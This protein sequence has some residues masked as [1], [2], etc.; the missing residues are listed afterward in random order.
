[1][2]RIEKRRRQMNTTEVIKKILSEK[3]DVSNLN[4]NDTLTSLGL[5]S[6]DL[7][8]VMIAIEEEIGVEFT[9]AEILNLKTL[10]DVLDL[11]ESKKK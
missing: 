6:L 2:S 9:S 10:K 7:A 11:I 8:E 4:E 1:M 3:I 5:D